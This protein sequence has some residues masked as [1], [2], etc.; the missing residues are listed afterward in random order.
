MSKESEILN[1]RVERTD[2]SKI[3]TQFPMPDLL[4]IQRQSYADFLQMDLLP[5]ERKDTGLQS[6]FKD[7]FP[8]S[9]FKETTAL[10]FISYSIGNWE[11]KCGR[12]KGVDNSRARC[13]SCDTLLTAELELTE[14][15]ICPYCSAMRKIETPTCEHCGDRVRLKLKYNPIEC[16]QKGYTFSV[17]LRLKVRL[18]SWEKDANTKSKRLK[19]IKEQEVYFGDIPLMT[20]KGTFIFNG[21][22]RVVVSQ[23]QRSPG[24]FFR[25]GETKGF[26]IGK[27]I[28][29]RGAW[30][31]FEFDAKNSLFVRLDRKKKFLASVFLRALGFGSDEDII[32][33]FYDVFK[34]IPEDGHLYW[35]LGDQLV[36]KTV[37]EDI[38]APHSKKVLA[39]ARTKLTVEVIKELKD[40]GVSR[41]P[42]VKK[43]LQ[44][45]Y[46]L[47][48]IKGKVKANEEMGDVQLDLL[49]GRGEPF[50]IFFPE[51]DKTGMII[52][53]TLKKDT[54][55]DTNQAL[56]EIYRKLRPGEPT[57][58]K[59]PTI[60]S[61]TISS[62]PRSTISRASAG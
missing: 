50:E 40:K 16:I 53:N 47:S 62:T 17:P 12:L 23:L 6:A 57:P 19:H 43:E 34:I 7:V 35:E 24:V 52:S 38:C 58:W 20:D 59:A 54:R 1:H 29:Y 44:G 3:G 36:G 15:E 33:L 22:E 56:A 5:E 8:I 26:F 28:P 30:V 61:I 51:L 9:D 39:S 41:V 55:K 32:R 60:F 14:K 4:A 21:I 46:S 37:E 42:L 27:I 13:K 18:I 11:C 2:F 25:P 49:T 45:A 10:D 48:S 31:E